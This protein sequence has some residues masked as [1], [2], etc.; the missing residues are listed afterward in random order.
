MSDTI[1]LIVMK[2]GMNLLGDIVEDKGDS[3]VVKNPAM[4]SPIPGDNGRLGFLPYLQLSTLDTCEFMMED[5]MH[6]F[7][8][9]IALRNDW[10]RMY[11]TGI[12]AANQEL[13]LE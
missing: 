4:I 13:I 1:K 3:I 6:V 5:I 9:V 8:P 10:N 2:S 11:G 7:P 12:I